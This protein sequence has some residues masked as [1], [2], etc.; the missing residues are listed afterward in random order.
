MA[1]TPLLGPRPSR[2]SFLLAGRVG[3]KEF[4]TQRLLSLQVSQETCL[5]ALQA[6]WAADAS[7][8][9]SPSRLQ[10]AL[11]AEPPPVFL[12]WAWGPGSSP[13]C[14][15]L[16]SKMRSLSGPSARGCF[17]AVHPLSLDTPLGP[18]CRAGPTTKHRHLSSSREATLSQGGYAGP[19]W[20][21]ALG[22]NHSF[23]PGVSTSDTDAES[24]LRCSR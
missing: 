2:R 1:A 6:V 14:A 12:T 9:G 20:T 23:Y 19:P 4:P 11:E 7:P 8:S 5:L 17:I 21:G 22:R 18:D 16:F 15:Q 3:L 10:P 13:E 24:D